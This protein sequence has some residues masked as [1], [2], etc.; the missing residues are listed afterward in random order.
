M[1]A[2]RSV[3]LTW[4]LVLSLAGWWTLP[5]SHVWAD[6]QDRFTILGENDSLYFNSD[7][8]YTQGPR[9]SDLR[10]E[11]TLESRWNGPCDLLGTLAPVFQ[12]NA[13]PPKRRFAL[14]FG[15]SLFTPKNL[16]LNAPA[17]RDR[18]YA[19]WAYVGASLLQET[20]GRMLENFEIDLG[21]V[22]PAALGEPVQNTF[23][24]LSATFGPKAGAINS[25]TSRER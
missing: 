2:A 7:K 11:L 1:I 16:R 18:S 3:C 5:A 25:T 4:L 23:T 8:H 17:A 13:S 14:L 6:D 19:A 12:R 10:P 22:G 24:G 20:G 21:I 9:L 15:Q